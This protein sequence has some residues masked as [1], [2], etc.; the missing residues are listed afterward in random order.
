MI[1]EEHPIDIPRVKVNKLN[2]IKNNN[3]IIKKNISFILSHLYKK[4]KKNQRN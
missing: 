1:Q 2:L 4:K 3:I